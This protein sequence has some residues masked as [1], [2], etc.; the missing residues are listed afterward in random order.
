MTVPESPR[1]AIVVS[2]AWEATWP[3]VAEALRATW[4]QTAPVALVRVDSESWAT[5]GEVVRAMDGPLAPSLCASQTAYAACPGYRCPSEESCVMR[6]LWLDVRNAIADILDR[7][8]FGDRLHVVRG[9]HDAYEGQHEY[10]GDRWIEVPGAAVALLDTEG[11][12][13]AR[14]VGTLERQLLAF[15]QRFAGDLLVVLLDVDARI[16]PPFAAGH[17]CRPV[18]LHLRRHD[19][20]RRAAGD[21]G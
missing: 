7:T 21:Q 19:P 10:A 4:S 6:D 12:R 1:R 9:N 5:V 3:L 2:A 13:L 18:A 8:T 17:A 15:D 16:G 14:E 20:H 11:D